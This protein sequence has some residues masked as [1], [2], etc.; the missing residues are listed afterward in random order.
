MLSKI[1][2]S[3]LLL[4]TAAS[5]QSQATKL[6]SACEQSVVNVVYDQFGRYDETFSVVGYK[7][8]YTGFFDQL[9]VVRTSDEVEPRDVLVRVQ[10][11]KNT[12]AVEFK[13]TLADGSVADIEDLIELSQSPQK[14]A[15]KYNQISGTVDSITSG[16]IDPSVIGEAC[17]IVLNTSAGKKVGL[18]TSQYDCDDADS[19][20]QGSTVTASVHKDDRIKD[21][22]EL[23]VLKGFGASAFFNVPF[24]EIK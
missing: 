14:I 11:D 4:S 16:E 21:K 5:A 8:I 15:S 2:F 17:V 1:F 20:K 19:V 3:A 9:A 13:E 24:S 10:S 6:T 7:V 12:C 23:D 22:K 18:I